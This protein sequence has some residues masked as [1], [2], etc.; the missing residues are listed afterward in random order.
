MKEFFFVNLQVDTSQLH[1]RLTPPQTVFCTVADWGSM[2]H[3]VTQTRGRAF[4]ILGRAFDFLLSLQK[5]GRE[6]ERLDRVF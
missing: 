2:G 1:N 4:Q 5:F 6:F 3:A